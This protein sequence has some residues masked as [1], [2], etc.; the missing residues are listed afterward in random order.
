MAFKQ[1]LTRRS[2]IRHLSITPFI[3]RISTFPRHHCRII[4]IRHISGYFVA[5][6][7]T[8]YNITSTLGIGF[9]KAQQAFTAEEHGIKLQQLAAD[10]KEV[11][12]KVRIASDWG[13]KQS[14]TDNWLRV[15]S[16]DKTGP[17]LLQDPFAGEKV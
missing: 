4:L 15:V 10:T 7:A 11:N 8:L 2:P 6:A 9:E 5:L 16:G 12:D 13:V 3:W 17:A 1:A 14:N